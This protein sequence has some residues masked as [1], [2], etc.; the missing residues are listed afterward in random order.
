MEKLEEE[1]W[2]RAPGRGKV[3]RRTPALGGGCAGLIGKRKR[4]AGL[5]RQWH[6]SLKREESGKLSPGGQEEVFPT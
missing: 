2:R 5:E 1:N 3:V 4:R 6:R